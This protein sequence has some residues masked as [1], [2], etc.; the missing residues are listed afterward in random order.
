MWISKHIH[1][2]IESNYS[3]YIYILYIIHIYIYI[4]Y[5]IYIYIY[6]I[7]SYIPWYSH[8][9][10]TTWQFF[11]VKSALPTS[12][13]SRCRFGQLGLPP[14]PK[15]SRSATGCRLDPLGDVEFVVVNV[16]NY[17]VCTVYIYITHIYIHIICMYASIYTECCIT[18]SCHF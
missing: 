12:P 10:P 14:R 3:T 6:M 7:I 15:R 5:N 13:R 17:S 2:S 8:S 16:T 18:S 1:L 9:Y 4:S 11:M